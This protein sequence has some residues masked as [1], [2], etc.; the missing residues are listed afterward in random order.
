MFS[1]SVMSDSANPWTVASLIGLVHGISSQD[2]W[3]ALPCPLPG[4]LPDPGIKPI[5]PALAGRL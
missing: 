1:H 5:A 4:D 2:Y 3:S